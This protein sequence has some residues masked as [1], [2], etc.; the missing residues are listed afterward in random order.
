VE[1]VNLIVKHMWGKR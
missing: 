1:S